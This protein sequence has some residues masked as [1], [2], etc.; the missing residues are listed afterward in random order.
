MSQSARQKGDPVL[1]QIWAQHVELHKRVRALA[2]TLEDGGTIADVIAALARLRETL[3][4]HFA[5]EERG[6]YFSLVLEAAPDLRPRADVLQ[7]HHGEFLASSSAIQ[8]SLE[9]LPDC[10]ETKAYARTRI[11]E[12]IGALEAHEAAENQLV[13]TALDRAES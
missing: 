5:L 4:E 6:G 13:R 12:L 3:P 8:K 11:S 2:N 10:P 7:G 1:D 9:E